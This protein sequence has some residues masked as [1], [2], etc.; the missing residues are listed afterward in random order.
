MHMKNTNLNMVQHLSGVMTLVALLTGQAMSQQASSVVESAK[1]GSEERAM[2]GHFG[3]NNGV[4][5]IA[6]D[7]STDA[8]FG[9]VDGSITLPVLEKDLLIFDLYA[10]FDNLG[11]SS[12][13][14]TDEDPRYEF[15]LGAHYLRQ[16][17]QDTRAGLFLGYGYTLSQDEDHNDS[18]DVIMSGFEVQHFL[19]DEVLLFGQFG[20]GFKAKNGQD[21]QE[22]FNG[23]LISRIGAA[24]FPDQKSSLIVDLEAAGTDYY[25][26]DTGDDGRFFG[27]CLGYERALSDNLPLYLNGF[28]NYNLIDGT[29]DGQVE[30]WQI[31]L[32]FRYYFGAESPQDAARK[33]KSIG[34]PRLPTRGLAWAEYLD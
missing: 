32:G 29:D 3:I 15:N 18:Y 10:R 30:E 26:D 27:V 21:E 13:F 5:S 31:G 4:N 1:V 7:R 6:A 22:G 17:T 23:G 28:A 11:H 8:W 34:V 19:T 12:G 20:M 14:D 24:F 9:S 25:L 16:F 2:V 33:G